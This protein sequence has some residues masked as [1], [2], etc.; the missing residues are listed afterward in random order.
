MVEDTPA[1][2]SPLLQPNHRLDSVFS[3]GG[4]LAENRLGHVAVGENARGP[5]F[6]PPDRR[7]ETTRAAAR[8]GEPPGH[9]LRIFGIEFARLS[10]ERLDG[11]LR[12][13][14]DDFAEH[15]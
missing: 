2:D 9:V 5:A 10:D 6:V 7:A 11:L 8:F 1:D 4:R 13:S 14:I 15:L 3:G 12:F